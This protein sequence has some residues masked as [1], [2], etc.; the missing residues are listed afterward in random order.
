[1]PFISHLPLLWIPN[2]K[3]GGA[4]QPLGVLQGHM[5][6]ANPQ[7]KYAPAPALHLLCTCSAPA[8]HL[9]AA[10]A[11][12]R[13]QEKGKRGRGKREEMEGKG[14]VTQTVFLWVGWSRIFQRNPN[15]RSFEG[16]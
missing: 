11:N 16:L 7:W 14:R 13:E 3:A 10:A 12:E 15:V 6:L 4:A 2:P 1:M 9:H 5:A 8:L